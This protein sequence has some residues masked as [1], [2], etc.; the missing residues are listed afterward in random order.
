MFV[1]DALIKNPDRNNGNWGV[2]W[3]GLGYAL[4]PVYDN[5][6]SL[7]SKRR[8]SVMERCAH[9]E[10]DVEEDA[11]GT[12]VSAYLVSG[13][14]G[15]PHHIHPFDYMRETDNPDLAAAIRR[16]VERTD[17]VAVERLF[18]E[19]PGEAFGWRLMTEGARDAQLALIRKRFEEGLVPL[20]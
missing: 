8:D 2:L 6:S 11:F 10:K 19:I 7:F 12:N 14:D 1:V 3:D 13:E 15:R 18:A 9:D 5:G 20:A 17:L 4:A 16:I